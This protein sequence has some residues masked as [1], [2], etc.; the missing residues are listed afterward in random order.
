M[1]ALEKEMA[2]HRTAISTS[3]NHVLVSGQ[4]CRRQRV[5]ILDGNEIDRRV[6]A[7]SI[8]F[9]IK[10]ETLTFIDFL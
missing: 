10:L 8:N 9:E 7:S 1:R 4:T 3:S 6:L 5:S 2:A